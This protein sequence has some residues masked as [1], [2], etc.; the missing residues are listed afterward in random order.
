MSTCMAHIVNKTFAIIM[1]TLQFT[2]IQSPS[3]MNRCQR[4]LTIP[5]TGTP[6]NTLAHGA[7]SSSTCIFPIR[8]Q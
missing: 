1:D 3:V 6:C 4:N 8:C 2:V 5:T 7:Q